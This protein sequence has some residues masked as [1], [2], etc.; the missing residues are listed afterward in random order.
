MSEDTCSLYDLVATDPRYPLEA[1]MFVREALS[2]ASDSLELGSLATAECHLNSEQLQQARRERH[3]TGQELCEAIRMYALNQFGYMA[4][5]V[6]Q[7]W[8]I[9]D[10]GC[11]G[12][13]VYNMIDIGIMKKSSRDRRSHFDDIY[14][15]DTAFDSEFKICCG[16]L[17]ERRV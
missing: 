5:V 2:F 3:L 11:F 16:S 17:A 13:I 14:N 6:L 9:T 15:F 10:T 7:N 4:K 8:R 1:Y 12:D